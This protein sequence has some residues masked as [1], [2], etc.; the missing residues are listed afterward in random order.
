MGAMDWDKAEKLLGHAIETGMIPGAAAAAGIGDQV[1]WKTVQG[2]AQIEGGR[3]ALREDTRFDLASLTKVMA[4]LPSILLLASQGD[5]S[6]Q[7]PVSRYLPGFRDTRWD[8]VSL[9]HLLTH[10]GGLVPHRN[11][12][13]TLQGLDAYVTAIAAEPW[14]AAPGTQVSYSDLG[15]ITLGAVVEAVSGTTL[16]RFVQEAVFGPLGIADAGYRPQ[17]DLRPTCAATEMVEGA[18]LCGVVHDENARAIGGVAGHA[19]LFGTLD[20]VSRYAMAWTASNSVLSPAARRAATRVYTQD[21]NGRRGLG[22]ALPGDGYDVGGDF[23]PETGAGHT[24]FTGT[25]L[26]FDPASGIWAVLLTNRVH[27][28][29]GTNINPLRRRF[30]NIVTTLLG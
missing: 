24:G 6:L 15:F 20:A 30:H 10:S 18:V 17:D 27:F 29:R 26:Q 9:R 2:W 23:W 4:T 19:G 7:D 16:D 28:G 8:Q 11:Y 3:R 1:I 25:S 22:W 13:E 14:D 21:L 12:Y 5:V